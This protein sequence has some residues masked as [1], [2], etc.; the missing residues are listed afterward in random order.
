MTAATR[1]LPPPRLALSVTEACESLG[2]SWNTFHEA[3]EPEL[4]L[5]RVGRRKIVPVGELE[6]WLA[7]HAEHVLGGG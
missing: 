1:K 5:A 4:R 6:K 3:I 7:E 2:V